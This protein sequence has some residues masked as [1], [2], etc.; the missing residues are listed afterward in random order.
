LSTDSRIIYARDGK[1]QAK[2]SILKGLFRILVLM[3]NHAS[4]VGFKEYKPTGELP[5]I[6]SQVHVSPNLCR[7]FPFAPDNYG[8]EL[9]E[10]STSAILRQQGR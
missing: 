6:I 2:A 8:M 1:N 10:L 9:P 4:R 7:A 3:Y 5:T